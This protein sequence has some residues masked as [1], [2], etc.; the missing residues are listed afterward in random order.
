MKKL[1][2]NQQ[3]IKLFEEVF[4]KGNL[5]EQIHIFGNYGLFLTYRNVPDFESRKIIKKPYIIIQQISHSPLS[6]CEFYKTFYA[7]I[8]DFQKPLTYM[9]KHDKL[10]RSDFIKYA[11]SKLFD[12]KLTKK[13]DNNS[14]KRSKI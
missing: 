10:F 2:A 5:H 7:F 13:A 6:T 9:N 3:A 12:S 14:T 4:I 8:D 11:N 1:G